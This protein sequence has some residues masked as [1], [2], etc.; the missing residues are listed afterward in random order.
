MTFHNPLLSLVTLFVFAHSSHAQVIQY[1]NNRESIH[2]LRPDATSSV[3]F[4]RDILTILVPAGNA[5]QAPP[6]KKQIESSIS[7]D[8]LPDAPAET[9]VSTET[10]NEPLRIEYNVTIQHEQAKPVEGFFQ[11]HPLQAG[12]AVLLMYDTLE[13]RAL[14]NETIYQPMDF[15][16]IGEH[17][18]V[19]QIAPSL[20]QANLNQAIVSEK[21]AKSLLY[22]PAGNA[23][24]YGI[25]P[26]SQ[27]EHPLFDMEP[28]IL[29]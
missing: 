18:K 24:E 3:V 26:G 6:T 9:T 14:K 12:N 1:S 8:T 21:P 5:P 16:F 7:D 17:G 10:T 15:L 28:V 22:L 2:A 23:I 27:L 19:I 25:L 13:R 20:V 29:K 11:T 4:T